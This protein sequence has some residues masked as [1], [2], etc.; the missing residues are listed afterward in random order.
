V[1]FSDHTIGNTAAI[2][3]IV[4]GACFI[5][6]HF[7]LDRSLPGPDHQMSVD[8]QRLEKLV[9][10]IRSIESNIGN[11]S[12]MPTSSELESKYNFTLSCAAKADI[13]ENDILLDKDISYSRPGSGIPPAHSYLISGRRL[14]KSVQKGHIFSLEDFE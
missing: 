14:I 9:K 4:Y 3:S 6:K 7:T 10:G 2:G 5:E 8:P 13:Q 11:G 12:L 1:G